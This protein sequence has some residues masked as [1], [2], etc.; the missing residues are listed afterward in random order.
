M[1]NRQLGYVVIVSLQSH[2]EHAV[3]GEGLHSLFHVTQGSYK[4]PAECCFPLISSEVAQLIVVD[5]T[6]FKQREIDF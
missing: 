4:E 6:S 5:H 3:V 1:E 2:K